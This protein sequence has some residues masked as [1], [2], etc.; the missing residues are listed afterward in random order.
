[1]DVANITTL[2]TALRNETEKQSISPENVGY[3]LQLMLDLTVSLDQSGLSSD[4]STALDKAN[5]ALA[6][7]NE[8]K[9]V[10][11]TAASSAT[12]AVSVANSANSLAKEANANA[13]SAL[14]KAS[15]AQSIAENANTA[16]QEAI[17]AVN[18]ALEAVE[19]AMS[20]AET[21]A[22]TAKEAKLTAEEA[23]NNASVL[24]FGGQVYH[25]EEISSK[26]VGF[27]A[28]C[29]EVM[30]FIVRTESG[31]AQFTE[32]N[33]QNSEYKT[34]PRSDVLFRCGNSLYRWDGSFFDKYASGSEV[35]DTIN[36][37]SKYVSPRLFVNV[38]QLLHDASAM[39]LETAIDHLSGT[40]YA[41][42]RS[43]GVVLTFRS[44]VAGEGWTS[45]Q[46]LGEIWAD[47][48]RWQRFGG[49][50]SVGNC[51]NVTNEI[52]LGSGYY[53]FDSA[54]K[55]TFSKGVAAV[56]LQITYAVGKNS[57]KTYQFVGPDIQE[58]SFLEPANWIDLAV[59]TAGAEAIVNVNNLCGICTA[60]QSDYYTLAYAIADIVKKQNET[61]I[62]YAK[63]GLVI[64]YCIGE[65][66]WE[67][68]QFNGLVPDFANE[69][70]WK[71]FGN[72][73]SSNFNISDEPKT[74]G[75]EAFSTG[76]AAALLP[77]DIAVEN[78]DGVAYINMVNEKGEIIGNRQSIIVGTGS[79]SVGGTTIA[80][81][82]ENAPLY[83]AFGSEII[84]RVAIRSI[85]KSGNIESENAIERID[86]VDRDSGL[87]VLSK[88]VNKP[89]SGDLTD[90]SFEIDFT[91]F[92]SAAGQRK[93]KVV[94]TDD[95]DNSQAKNI[96]VTAVDVTCTCVQILHY[97]EDNAI[98]PSDST[99]SLPLY[100]FA[101]NTSD[102]GISV[103]VD[104]LIGSEWINVHSAVVLDSFSHSVSF[105][106]VSLGLTHGAYPLRIQG[107]DVA[108]GT[109]GNIIY[110]SV[111]IVDPNSDIP[112]V[113]IR[114]D[115]KNNGL[116]RLYDTVFLDVACYCRDNISPSVAVYVNDSI[117]TTL[118]AV[119]T[120]TYQ[121]SQQVQGR[122][123]GDSLN[124]VAV[125]ENVTSTEIALVV[126]GSAISAE[127]KEGALYSF[128]FS[129]RSN[130]E[131]DHSI[132]SGNYEMTVVGSNWSSN[133][134]ANFLGE[135]CLRIAE[136]VNVS[137]NHQL[138]ATPSIESTGTAIQFAF[139]SKNTTDDSVNLLECYDED[140]GAGF[141][142]TGEMVGIYC[143]NGIAQREER[144]YVQGEKTTVA[145]V[146][147]PENV[148]LERDGTRYAL[149]KLYINGEL[150]ACIGFIPGAGNLT[151]LKNITMNGAYGDLY[152]YYMIAWNDY[153]EWT[154]AFDNYLVKLSDTKAM[155]S[156]YDFEDVIVS[157]T[158]EGSTKNRPSAA[159]L[160]SRGMPYI[161]EAPWD[162]S[163]VDALDNTTSTSEN[164]Y[165]T[166]YYYNPKRPWTNFK[167]T[168]VR[169]RNQGTT[170]AKRPVKNKRYYLA[171][172]KGKNKDTEIVLLN[173]DDSTEAGR[174]AIALAAQNKVQVGDN[175]IPVDIITVKIDF[176]DSSN[177]NDCGICDMF[178]STFRALGDKYL[179]PAQRAYTGIYE[180]DDL[181][182]SDLQLNHST[183]NHS[184]VTF[185]S[186]DE[187]L[188]NVY[189]HAKGNWK[190]DKGEQ[191]AL[192]FKDTPGYNLGCL[193][194]GDFVEFFGNR[195]ES[196]D[197]IET[198]FKSVAGLDTSKI[199]LLSLYCGRDYRFMRYRDGVWTKSVGSM[200][201]NDDGTWSVI[202]DVLNP[203]DGFEL[204]N[205]Q[206]MCW[207]QGVGSVDDMMEMKE[208]RSSWVQKLV[209][210]GDVSATS[211]PAWTYY[212]ECMIDDDQLAIDYA[213]GKKVPYN[214]YRLLVFL[215]S[216]DYSKERDDWKLIWRENMYRYMSPYSVFSY[217]IGTDYNAMVDQRAKNMQPMFFLEDGFS[218]SDGVYSS[219]Y[220]VK[221]YLNKVYDSDS[222]NR[223][224][225]DGGCTVNPESDPNRLSDN[226]YTNPYAGYGSVLFNNIYLQQEVVI[227]DNGNT[228]A[229]RTVAAAMRNVQTNID[230]R[231]LKPF[232]PEGAMY[233][234]YEK[235]LLPWQ[236][237]VSSFDG[238]RKYINYTASSDS[239]YFYALQGL[240]LTSL[241]AFIKKR[242]RYRD[243]FFQTGEFFSGVVSG[244][245][246]ASANAKIRFTAA[247]SGYF[248]VGNDASGN[249][250]ESC[251]LEAGE[252]YEFTNFSHEEGALLYI[253]Q[254]DRMSMLDLSE[255]SISSTFNFAA[256]QLVQ[257]LI[258]GSDTHVE[259]AIGSFAP[260]TTL[261][262]GEMPFLN[263]LDVRNTQI[264]SMVC[265]KC[266][267][268][269]H[270]N[271]EGSSVASIVLAETSP[272]NDII[273][274]ESMS[275]IRLIGL[276]ALT[277]KGLNAVNG[278]Q[279]SSMPNVQRLR[280]ESSPFVNAVQMLLDVLNSQ[281]ETNAL[282][283]LR[284]V[285]MPTKGDADELLRLINLGV[286]GM[287]ADGN[288]QS[289]PVI[290][291]TYE[292]TKLYENWQILEIENAIDGIDIITVIDAYITLIN[293]I[294]NESFGGESEVENISLD[295]IDEHLLYY[296]GE[297]YDEYLTTLVQADLDINDLVT[298]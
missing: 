170:S 46:W 161:V 148:A 51:Y 55:A 251:Y 70:L 138:F 171:K 272:I 291:S 116:V 142:I 264:V 146:V 47:T 88:I 102:Q 151:Q 125:C 155:V 30:F 268:L 105:N 249:L 233:V 64:T 114:Y 145:I 293:E 107:T 220:A 31:Y 97:T 163:K 253:Y 157:Q 174:R 89:S 238:E 279:I 9:S 108:S 75:T 247:K 57:W 240:G 214:L 95:S 280:V 71:D 296:N 255:I 209:D 60:T 281:T 50:A 274:P 42:Y 270:I 119:R 38:N 73:D 193:N 123:D 260:L 93:F 254:A 203:V 39:S 85:T 261:N 262:L 141:Y 132:K 176:S 69:D 20:M 137:L 288:K 25:A 267:R 22:K 175:T 235:R 229:L 58:S 273:L 152:L 179:T 190:E 23:L 184:V 80:I 126:N 68:K 213:L 234:F 189:F 110:T 207:W 210:S 147:E 81:A 191:V 17:A 61:G 246:S 99:A 192:G 167:A 112:I 178:N 194:Y 292:L 275:D 162:G 135:N 248:G 100:K 149:M 29:A 36:T 65:N 172:S 136:N 134:F 115:D 16:V 185:R 242:W 34:V 109:K 258:L 277:Y 18:E 1:M 106:P 154:Q 52:P 201:Q 250:S 222:A 237:L 197:E 244:R 67:T 53:D 74:N 94:V 166:L 48:S 45:F 283:L 257:S 231:T 133:G 205:Y 212:F 32:Y 82:F 195:D 241:P 26:A 120:K 128:D 7:A 269:A 150:V 90:F 215:D 186:D 131:T 5:T 223:K 15:S 2:I 103:V 289:K 160:Y 121:V 206:G 56:G 183:A 182:I 278:L 188:Q 24:P 295:N 227:D 226:T 28:Y 153:F 139:A 10:A 76:G 173:P 104:M 3:I 218:V 265:D 144:A 6:T 66:T 27:I 239:I 266:P 181:T 62:T 165:I 204:L 276:P 187:T 113:A 202:G 86:V 54:V 294:N 11:D 37:L 221:M 96:N 225:N 44:S 208:D 156:E 158:A 21:A 122:I 230:G 216:C 143:K 290:Q 8:A 41:G 19:S 243:G 98:A 284:F 217:D 91:Q 164:N 287:D 33:T 169:S 271:A 111:M 177:A 285:D 199:Y 224:D 40:D 77:A 59:M 130:A 219:E 83:G 127:L 259:L 43:A 211:F 87:T 180:K 124:Y 117:I 228:L 4:V 72:G 140:S 298:Q 168:S 14:D 13:S 198:R 79:G 35:T 84:A 200:T 92:F 63:K 263:T 256:M 159:E 286:A 12:A 101:N 78:G 297:T 118:S 49:R 282:Q 245:I 232:S 129:S 236:K 196:L 252:S